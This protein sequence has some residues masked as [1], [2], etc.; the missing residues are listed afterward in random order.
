MCT[1]YER[2]EA[3]SGEPPIKVRFRVQVRGRV[4]P[5]WLIPRDAILADDD[6]IEGHTS[7]GYMVAV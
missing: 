1:R 7:M 4:R 5:S 6:A 2:R 3:I